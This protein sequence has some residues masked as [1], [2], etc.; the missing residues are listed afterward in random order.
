MGDE[1]CYEFIDHLFSYKGVNWGAFCRIKTRAYKGCNVDAEPFMSGNTFVNLW[2]S[3]AASLGIDF[4]E[5]RDPWCG[6]CPELLAGDGTHV[7]VTLRHLNICPIEQ[8]ECDVERGSMY[9]R[10]THTVFKY[11]ERIKDEDVRDCR[12]QM[13]LYCQSIL[14]GEYQSLQQPQIDLILM[15]TPEQCRP[16]IS[17]FIKGQLFG[18]FTNH[19]AELIELLSRDAAVES[20]IPL[21]LI[22][23]LR[24]AL[25]QLQLNNASPNCIENLIN[26]GPEIKQCLQNAIDHDYLQDLMQFLQYLC[27]FVEHY[28]SNDEQAQDSVPIANSYNPESGVAYYFTQS[29]NQVRKLG[30]YKINKGKNEIGQFDD[31]PHTDKCTKDYVKVSKKGFSHCFLWFCPIHGHAYGFHIIHS[32][33]G[34]KDPFAS[35]YKYMPKAPNHVFYDFAC[36]LSE[37]CL[38]REPQFFSQ[39]RFWHD[40]FHSFV[41]LCGKMFRSRRL[42]FLNVNS[43]IAEQYNSFIQCI[44]YTGSHLSQSKFCFLMQFCMYWWNLR[45][46]ESYRKLLN[47]AR[48][49]NM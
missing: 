17:K 41:H 35:L 5:F 23:Q 24:D 46:T 21:P 45:K 30:K 47:I 26:I 9:R 8:A 1:V 49:G 28:H 38:N 14:K 29:G 22:P 10:F 43:E 2:F 44:K 48:L 15:C 20:I 37:Y 34:R 36:S 40:L 27:D 18:S 25:Q 32:S 31:K 3:W 7:G 11:E 19:L 16:L 6:D 13:V 4:R 12:E 33:E 39:T 42:P